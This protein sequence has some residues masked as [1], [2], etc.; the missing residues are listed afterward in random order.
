MNVRL[1]ILIMTKATG[2]AECLFF[3]G[4]LSHYKLGRKGIVARN[5]IGGCTFL[6]L[7]AEKLTTVGYNARKLYYIVMACILI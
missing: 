1:K 6:A 2:S 5:A 7:R 3:A 4:L